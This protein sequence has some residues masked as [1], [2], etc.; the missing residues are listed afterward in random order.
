[1]AEAAGTIRALDV[2]FYQSE[3]G[4]NQR[5]RK[6]QRNLLRTGGNCPYCRTKILFYYENE[7]LYG[8]PVRTCKKCGERYV[9]ERYHEIAVEGVA[10]GTLSAKLDGIGMLVMSGIFLIAFLIH[11][12][13][14]SN[15]SAYSLEPC[16]I[17]VIALLG[18]LIFII[19]S[20]RILT[21]AKAKK[22]AKLGRES[23]QRLQNWSYAK[24][25]EE[26]GYVVPE[27][28]L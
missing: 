4:R 1:M 24:E 13:E 25:L 8:S 3:K 17:M 14:V 19:D 27:K 26:L 28:Y 15:N 7:W 10:P 18:I 12:Y 6:M 16:V 23:E 11:F 20:V 9:D 5:G 2:I 21:G 22:L